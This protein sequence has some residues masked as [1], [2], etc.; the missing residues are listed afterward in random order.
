MNTHDDSFKPMD[1][2][3]ADGCLEQAADF[4]RYE[5]VQRTPVLREV[6]RV[7]RFEIEADRVLS[8]AEVEKAYLAQVTR[9]TKY[10]KERL[11]QILGINRKTLYRK[12]KE[13][14]L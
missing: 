10:S 13:Y 14:N 12:R 9:E 6:K 7:F 8:L 2:C 3:L 4:E 1:G 5:I 11:A